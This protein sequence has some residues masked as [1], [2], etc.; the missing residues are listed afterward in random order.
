[1]TVAVYSWNGARLAG[2]TSTAG[3]GAYTVTGLP[4][5]I[6]FARTNDTAWR[7]VAYNNVACGSCS[8]TTSEPIRVNAGVTTP[9]INFAL[10]DSVPG[11]VTGTVT[12]AGTAAPIPSVEVDLYE[13][14]G[15]TSF[16][17]R[18]NGF[19]RA[20]GTYIVTGL[21]AGTYVAR[22]FVLPFPGTFLPNY[23]DAG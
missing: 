4:P 9:S 22:T 12:D 21:P 11:S 6:Y 15:P 3:T 20:D 2:V 23:M 1:M 18:G 17:F 19:S 14:L 13:Q 10:S 5:G 8:V 7:D 16:Q